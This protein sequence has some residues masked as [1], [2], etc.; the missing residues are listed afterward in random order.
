MR[1]D[2][3]SPATIR[4]KMQRGSVTTRA[5]STARRGA[6]TALVAAACLGAAGCAS[7]GSDGRGQDTDERTTAAAAPAG[8]AGADL[9]APELAPDRRACPAGEGFD[10]FRLRVALDRT[11]R[12]SGVSGRLTL[13]VAVET[14]TRPPGRPPKGYL[15]ALTGGPGQPG[16]PFAPSTRKRLGSVAPGYALVLVDQRGTGAGALDCPQL[17]RSVGASDVAVAAR[18]SVEACAR[19]VGSRRAAFTTADTVADLEDLRQALGAERL[20]FAGVSYGSF[21]AERYALAHPDR[22]RGLILDSVVRQQGADALLVHNMAAVPRVLRAVCREVHCRGDVGADLRAALAFGADDVALLDT[23]VTK[24]LG[25]PRL[26]EVPAALRE[27][28][29]GRLERLGRLSAEAQEEDGAPPAQFSAGLHAATLCA[30]SDVPW[31]DATAL[32]ADREQGLAQARAQ[33]TPGRLGGFEP[34]TAVENGLADTCRRWPPLPRAPASPT[35]PLPAVPTLLLAGELDL[36][37]PLED[38]REQLSRA[39]AGKLVVVPGVGHSVLSSDPSGCALRAAGRFL[40][41]RAPGGCG[42]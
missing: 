24:S 38:A 1:D 7:G 13:R 16:L 29:R 26:D 6:V 15:V 8:P 19:Q 31:R 14:G 4:Q 42:R 34:A 41:G 37:T 11:G 21:V 5:K 17:Q 30:E 28:A 39:P 27:A 10:C 36:A 32:P 40:A 35:G 12:A 3:S 23:L 2:G 9:R 33:L 20:T 18:G 25:V 22:V